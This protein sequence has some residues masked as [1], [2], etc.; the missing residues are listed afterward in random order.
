MQ[1]FINNIEKCF[2]MFKDVAMFAN[3]Q[4]YTRQ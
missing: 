2:A 4:G 1:K 3:V